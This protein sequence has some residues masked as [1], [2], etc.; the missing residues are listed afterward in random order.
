MS[1]YL[2][3]HT[4]TAAGWD[5]P[6]AVFVTFV[7]DYLAGWHW[8]LYAGRTL[9]GATHSPTARRVVGQVLADDAPATLT[10]IRV[11]AANRLTDYGASLP[12]VPTH[13][14]ALEWTATG[15]PADASH[16]DLTGNTAAGGDVDDANLIARIEYRGDFGYR[17]ELPPLPTAG[18]WKYRLTPRD[19]ALPSGNAGTAANITIDAELPPPDFALQSDGN[20][21][22]L[23]VDE[24]AG[25]LVAG[26]AYA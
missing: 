23:T 6:R 21:F 24:G 19:N 3:G 2:G 12:D 17:F 11:D 5:G 20:R 26:F 9:I 4:I 1:F 8:Q 22:T 25:E 15:Y 7:S 16:W 13:R 18:E 14:F 10:L